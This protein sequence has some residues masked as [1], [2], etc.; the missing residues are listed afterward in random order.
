M[1]RIIPFA[2]LGCKF[3][4]HFRPFREL[5]MPAHTQ[6][7]LMGSSMVKMVPFGSL[8]LVLIKPW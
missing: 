4:G 2:T 5:L 8:S 6:A 1:H 7:P 3:I